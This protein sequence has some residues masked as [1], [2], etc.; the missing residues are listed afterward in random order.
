MADFTTY[1]VGLHN[2]GSYMVSGVPYIT[3]SET[4]AKNTEEK[5]S[6]PFVTNNFTVVNHTGDTIRVHFN[7]IDTAT[8]LT[9]FHY[10]EL[11]SDEDSFTFNVKCKEV[12]ISAPNTG[13]ARKWRIVAS[14]TQIP[15]QQ[16]FEI[17]GPGLTDAP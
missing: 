7:S 4:M 8:V 13:S 12:Y 1:R 14:L 5:V 3:G 6:F 9:G 16:M 17:S 10:V 2:V 15:A 11:D